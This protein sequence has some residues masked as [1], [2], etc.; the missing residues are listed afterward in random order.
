MVILIRIVGEP[1]GMA[2]GAGVDGAKQEITVD[3]LNYILCSY[4]PS[5]KLIHEYLSDKLKGPNH[6][7]LAH[8]ALSNLDLENLEERPYYD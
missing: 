5:R 2:I 4:I 3:L 6:S 8:E 1:I 7:L